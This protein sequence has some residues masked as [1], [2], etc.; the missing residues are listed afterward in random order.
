MKRLT[1][2]KMPQLAFFPTV[3]I[4]WSYKSKCNSSYKY[5]LNFMWLNFLIIIRFGKKK[6]HYLGVANTIKN[7]YDTSLVDSANQSRIQD[8][9]F[10]P[11]IVKPQDSNATVEFR[12]H[13]P[14]KQEDHK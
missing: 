5:G 8:M 14:L 6:Y 9:F 4:V 7:Y 3:G 12:R 2:H 1:F 10:P 11:K 13:T